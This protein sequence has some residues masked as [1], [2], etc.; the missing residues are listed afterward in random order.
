MG[1]SPRSKVQSEESPDTRFVSPFCLLR[2]RQA[3]LDDTLMAPQAKSWTT[4]WSS[5]PSTDPQGRGLLASPQPSQ[6]EASTSF[7]LPQRR[8]RRQRMPVDLASI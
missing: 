3:K 7:M 4:C 5:S 8:Q 2:A 6:G 1:G